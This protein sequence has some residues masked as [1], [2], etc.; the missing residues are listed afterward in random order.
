MITLF[1]WAVMMVPA[2]LWKW[3][4]TSSGTPHLG[5]HA[6]ESQVAVWQP[7]C[8]YYVA[9]LS[10]HNILSFCTDVMALVTCDEPSSMI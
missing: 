6:V 10:I 3:L 1:T 5:I 4:Q 7:M 8:C 9:S 2:T